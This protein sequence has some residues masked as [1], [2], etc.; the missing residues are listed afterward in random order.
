MQSRLQG[1][2]KTFRKLLNVTPKIVVMALYMTDK[3]LSVLRL[4]NSQ[5][6][7]VRVNCQIHTMMKT[8][9]TARRI[10]GNNK[11]KWLLAAISAKLQER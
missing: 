11:E 10:M 6:G 1:C 4:L 8:G 9:R 3:T 7:D 2:S 5:R